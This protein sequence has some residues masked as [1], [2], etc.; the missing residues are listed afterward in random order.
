MLNNG[1]TSNDDKSWLNAF[2]LPNMDFMLFSDAAFHY[3]EKLWLKSA[4]VLS[5]ELMP[6]SIKAT[7]YIGGIFNIPYTP[8]P[9]GIAMQTVDVSQVSTLHFLLNLQYN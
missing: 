6:V 1:E 3:Y 7:K 2:A 9:H 5:M 4:A 8:I